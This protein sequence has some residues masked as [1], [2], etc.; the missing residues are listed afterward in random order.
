MNS[1]LRFFAHFPLWLLRAF[2]HCIAT[3]MVLFPH[4]GM[5]WTARVNLLL[6]MPNLTL[7]QR[8]KLERQSVHS[9]C[10]TAM[11][12]L[13]CWGMPASY[14]IAQ[15]RHVQGL[16]ILKTAL[17]DANG[18]IAVVP[19]FGTWE[20][21]NAWL[22]QFGAPTIMYKPAGHAGLNRFMFDARQR[23][24]ATLVPTDERGVR[25]IFK[26]LK[27]GGFT[28]ILPDHVPEPSGGIF[29]PFYGHEVMTSTLVSKLA[30]KTQCA[31]V[32][33]SCNRRADG[34]GF[35]VICELLSDSIHNQDLKTSV[36][37][38]NDGIQ[39]MIQRAPE[40]YV[41]SYRR[42]KDAADFKRVYRL[43]EAAISKIATDAVLKAAG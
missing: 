15:I 25:A 7:N 21:M 39:S 5:R 6:T 37:A 2:A 19:H 3:L 20:M 28:I 34:D 26:T 13:K 22:N 41:W 27:K 1:T 12:S 4:G 35:T 30:Q 23:L 10:L 36:T 9:Q 17:N 31:V 11:E 43:D 42:F 33:L 38:L 24:N 14:S 16:D 29:A 40:Q 8:L 32:G 18:M